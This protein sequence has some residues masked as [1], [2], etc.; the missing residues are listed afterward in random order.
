MGITYLATY[1][2]ERTD[3]QA[4]IIDFTYHRRDWQQ[5]LRKSIEAFQP[6]IIGIST[7]SVYMQYVKAMLKEIKARY[8]LPTILGGYHTTLISDETI[9]L[10]GVDAICIGDGEYALAEYMDVLEGGKSPA[11]IKGIWFKDNDRVV[12]N[13]LREVIQDIDN[14][15]F[16]NYDLWEDFDKFVFYNELIYLIGN[17]GCPYNCTYCSEEPMRERLTGNYLR[18]RDPRAFVRE[19]KFHWEKYRDLGVR[20]AHTFD[21]VFTFNKKWVDEF[22]DEY[23]KQ[24]LSRVL[25]F[26]CFSRADNLNEEIIH[27]MAAA[28][29]KIIRIGIEA[30]NEYIRNEV[31]QKHIP[32]EQYRK[33]FKWLH[34]TEIAVTGYNML[35]G[36]GESMETMQDTFDFVKELKVDRPIFFTYRPLPG[37]KAAKQVAELGGMVDCNTW[38]QIDS[39]HRQ[40]NVYTKDLTPRQIVKFRYKCLWYFTFRRM[41]RLIADQKLKFFWNIARYIT[42]GI[43]DGVGFEYIVG[44]FFVSG[45]DNVTH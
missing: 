12:K 3:H 25:P 32:N 45:G 4:R 40:S 15:P 28:G 10:P 33:V 35:G 26:S 18:M 23:I 30:G 34:Q 13:E 17:R 27:T 41:L 20:V 7:V 43:R 22:C 42:H 37:T 5:H 2:N 38:E 11:G 31:Y 1:L 19:I 9:A 36:P 6:Q 39:L 16:P 14:L 21:P 44:Y 29:L 24:G 8:K